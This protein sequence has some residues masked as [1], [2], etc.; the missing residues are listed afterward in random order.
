MPKT[1]LRD[2][3]SYKTPDI[4]HSSTASTN[5]DGQHTIEL[6]LAWLY[7]KSAP[8]ASLNNA[9]LRNPMSNVGHDQSGPLRIE[10]RIP[11]FLKVS[12]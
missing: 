5:P 8:V 2:N 9:T 7:Q 12:V 10:L 6:S 1:S 4:H 3:A 11:V